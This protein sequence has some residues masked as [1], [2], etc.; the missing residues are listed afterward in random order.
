MFEKMP[1]DGPEYSH[2]NLVSG[3]RGDDV[4]SFQLPINNFQGHRR[5]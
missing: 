4:Q 5:F 3:H 1:K 2:R